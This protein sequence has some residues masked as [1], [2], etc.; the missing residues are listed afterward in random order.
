MNDARAWRRAPGVDTAAVDRLLLRY[1]DRVSELVELI[2][3]R[4]ELAEPLDHADGHLAAEVVHACTHEG[5][6]H[7]EDVLERRTRLGDHPVR[8]GHR[9]GC[10]APQR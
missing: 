1:G 8:S 3:Q 2:E 4:P 6:L 10:V 7:L 5:A 9:G